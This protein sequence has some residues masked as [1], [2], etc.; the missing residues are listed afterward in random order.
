[1]L[2]TLFQRS[3]HVRR[4]RANPLGAILDQ[5]AGYLHRRGHK[6]CR[7]SVRPCRGALR[8]LVGNMPRRRDRGPGHQGFDPTFL[9]DH[10]A[11]CSCPVGF[12]RSLIPS[13]AAVNHLLRMLDQQD[14]ARLV[15][16][17]TPYGPLLTEYDRFLVRP[18]GCPSIPASIACGTPESFWTDISAMPRRPPSDCGPRISRTIS[19]AMPVI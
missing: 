7:S 11:A 12:P 6:P 19:D 18:A 16:P 10:L 15:P 8:T 1:M 9:H 3:H 14:P 5:F 13:R 2:E 17:T 4:L